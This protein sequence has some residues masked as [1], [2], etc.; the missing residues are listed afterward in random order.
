MENE[1][2]TEL[3]R[4]ECELMPE[5]ITGNA[6]AI[7]M[8]VETDVAITT[9]KR[10]PLHSSAKDLERFEQKGITLATMSKETAEACLY[11][12]PRGRNP[13]EGRSIR[14][15]E[16]VAS[17]YGNMKSASRVIDVT[18]TEV[19]AQGVCI[20]LENNVSYSANCHRPILYKNGK[21]FNSDMITTTSNAA[22]S[23]ALRNAILKAVPAALTEKIY[24]AAK[25]K[26]I[27]S[28]L[29]IEATRAKAL[30][31]LSLMD[32]S[33]ARALRTLG[34][35]C[36]SAI[37]REDVSTLIGFSNAIQN[38]EVLI[39]D[40]FP[41]LPEET[42]NP[43][44]ILMEKLKQDRVR[45]MALANKVTPPTLEEIQAEAAE[46][47]ATRKRE[48]ESHERA[49]RGEDPTPPPPRAKEPTEAEWDK[50]EKEVKKG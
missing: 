34:R 7:A 49:L 18:E 20:D 42:M 31:T 9:A 1:K 25:D 5:I 3:V 47:E 21:R 41:P 2:G 13:I 50:I 10:Y 28:V 39:E 11:K 35:A 17:A 46:G 29:S 14:F 24:Q 33:E 43:A 48:K 36:I 15:A 23:I 26:A 40:A 45:E 38:K 6:L 19:I 22:S 30:K 44:E 8:Q 12:L 4:Q 32:I 16:I 27:G 37:T